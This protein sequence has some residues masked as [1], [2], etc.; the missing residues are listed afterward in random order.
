MPP[1][2]VEDEEFDQRNKDAEATPSDTAKSAEQ[3][4]GQEAE[5][6]HG[7]CLFFY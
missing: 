3:Q 1:T 6:S 2:K 5:S 4:D 7:D